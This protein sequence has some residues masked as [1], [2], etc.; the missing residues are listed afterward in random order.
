MCCH[1]IVHTLKGA[2]TQK[3]LGSRS[4]SSP[5]EDT[6][7]PRPGTPRHHLIRGI[8]SQ[9]CI[10]TRH[11]RLVRAPAA[12]GGTGRAGG[13]CPV[14]EAVCHGPGLPGSPRACCRWCTAWWPTAPGSGDTSWSSP[15]SASWNSRWPGWPPSGCH[16]PGR[17]AAHGG[18]WN[19]RAVTKRGGL[20]A[21][22]L[23][24]PLLGQAVAAK[25][26]QTKASHYRGKLCWPLN[27][28]RFPARVESVKTL[29]QNYNERK[30]EP[31]RVTT[32]GRWLLAERLE[33]MGFHNEDT[34]LPAHQEPRTPLARPFW[35]RD[36]V[37]H[38]FPRSVLTDRTVF[39]CMDAS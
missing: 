26:T 6:R 39:H 33:A 20:P 34:G 25:E 32:E 24:E 29:G 27:S 21:V 14:Q 30:W 35:H 1:L 19:R 37:R 4:P 36:S 22:L 16:T 9:M 7:R 11:P 13:G 15:R 17:A 8:L 28:R 5:P 18:P 10:L 2:L 31:Y 23:N 12:G 38:Y 3:R